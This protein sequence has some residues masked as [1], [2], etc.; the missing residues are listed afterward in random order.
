MV[1]SEW[2]HESPS[3]NCVAVDASV[4]HVC[5]SP[6]S[7]SSPPSSSCRMPNMT[8]LTGEPSSPSSP[9]HRTA[10]PS[11]MRSASSSSSSSRKGV[12]LKFTHAALYSKR[13]TRTRIGRDHQSASTAHNSQNSP[14]ILGTG[15]KGRMGS[16]VL[17]LVD[18]VQSKDSSSVT[19][20]ASG[21]ADMSEGKTRYV[22]PPCLSYLPLTYFPICILPPCR[23]SLS[24]S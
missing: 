16:G 3:F 23:T 5:P 1:E 22:A 21:M 7:S 10:S 13:T 12:D 6:H 2:S 9:M 8:L 11:R 15:V 20:D 19:V 24:L 17:A 18:K 14:S 4:E